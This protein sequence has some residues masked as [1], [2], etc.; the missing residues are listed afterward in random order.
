[1]TTFYAVAQGAQTQSVLA[2]PSWLRLNY[3]AY[4]TLRHARTHTSLTFIENFLLP[5]KPE[6]GHVYTLHRSYPPIIDDGYPTSPSD[7]SNTLLIFQYG[8]DRPRDGRLERTRCCTKLYH[9]FVASRLTLTPYT[10]RTLF[11]TSNGLSSLCI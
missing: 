3:R 7:S 8:V 1:M 10:H 6:I 2:N 4:A 9:G 11:C 5:A